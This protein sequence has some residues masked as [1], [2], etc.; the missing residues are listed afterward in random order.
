MWAQNGWDYLKTK[1]LVR[2]FQLPQQFEEIRSSLAK[3]KCFILNLFSGGW[4]KSYPP[5]FYAVWKEFWT[6]AWESSV[7]RYVKNW[8]FLLFTLEEVFRAKTL[9][10][11]WHPSGYW[12]WYLMT[13]KWIFDPLTLG[14]GSNNFLHKVWCW[15][16]TNV[17]IGRKK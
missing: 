14:K 4:G 13:P 17:S 11:F 12:G 9:M 16:G 7:R 3:V 8:Q 6:S 2:K 10:G 5:Q 15:W 1:V